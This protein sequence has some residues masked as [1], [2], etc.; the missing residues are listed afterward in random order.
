[1][2]L[3]KFSINTHAHRGVDAI[4]AAEEVKVMLA[5]AVT[6]LIQSARRAC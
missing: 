1:V 5:R 4:H 6:F 2:S 3:L